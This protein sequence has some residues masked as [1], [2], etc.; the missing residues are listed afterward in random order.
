[1]YLRSLTFLNAQITKEKSVSLLTI[2]HGDMNEKPC[3]RRQIIVSRHTVT[4]L[5]TVYLRSSLPRIQD[6]IY[7]TIL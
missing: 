6:H 5:Y 1:M 2:Q 4:F 7:V 3:E